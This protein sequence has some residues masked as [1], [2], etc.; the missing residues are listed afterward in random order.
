MA[1][2]SVAG[3]RVAQEYATS[4]IDPEARANRGIAQQCVKD[5]ATYAANKGRSLTTTLSKYYF[6]MMTRT[7]PDKLA[8]IGKL[9]EELFKLFL[10][11]RRTPNCSRI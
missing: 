10:G 6:P 9:R 3:N 2:S 1:L 8:E 4:P 5:P 11:R 7:E